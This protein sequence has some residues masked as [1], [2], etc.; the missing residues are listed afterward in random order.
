[1]RVSQTLDGGFIDPSLSGCEVKITGGNDAQGFPM[2]Q[3]VLKSTRVRLVLRKGSKC[4]RERRDA[5]P[6]R[7]SVRGCIVGPDLHAL[8][9]I[10]V[11]PKGKEIPGLTD[12]DIP[13]RHQPKRASK[14][15]RLF[16]VTEATKI[17]SEDDAKKRIEITQAINNE[18]RRVYT[19]KD[20]EVYKKV[21]IRRLVTLEHYKKRQEVRNHLK[22][23]LDA[24]RKRFN[25]H[26]NALKSKKW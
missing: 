1:M 17:K 4:F 19:R 11:D 21:G 8:N 20:K 22:A 24:N 9:V 10:L 23:V 13:N 6:K 12:V 5:E 2:L 25:E 7:K 18:L 16:G 15:R 3:G 14:I 26:K